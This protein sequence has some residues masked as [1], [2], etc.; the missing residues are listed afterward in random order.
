MNQRRRILKVIGTLGVAAAGC[1]GETQTAA[2]TTAGGGSTSSGEQQVPEGFELHGNLSTLNIGDVQG[3]KEQPIGV[4]R[5]AAGVYAMSTLCT[6]AGCDL[7]EG[8]I[9][10]TSLTCMC[11]GSQFDQNG[12]AIK[13][14]A[15]NALLHNET[16]LLANG[17]IYVNPK[18]FVEASF[19][20]EVT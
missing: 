16:L 18:S 6:H 8:T 17:D 9:D 12:M 11:H 5:D 15:V 10:K 14:P 4:L 13:G 3:F 7:L 2:T 20:S 1:G 19:R